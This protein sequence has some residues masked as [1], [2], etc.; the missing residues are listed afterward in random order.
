MVRAGAET[1]SPPEAAEEDRLDLARRLTGASRLACQAVV[2]GD[3][4]VE[5]VE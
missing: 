4:V 5:V 2:G 3:V 1:L